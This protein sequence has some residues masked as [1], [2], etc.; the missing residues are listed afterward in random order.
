LGTSAAFFFLMAITSCWTY[1]ITIPSGKSDSN[2]SR[3]SWRLWGEWVNG[4]TGDRR[5]GVTRALR[6]VAG[7]WCGVRPVCWGACQPHPLVSGCPATSRRRRQGGLFGADAGC[8]YDVYVGTYSLIGA[9]AFL[10]G[11]VR[12]TISLTVIL[13]E[14]TNE[15]G[16]PGPRP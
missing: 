5:F 15:V 11:V 6:A 8:R 3:G 16:W 13:V 2:G 1:G 4:R 7:D 10:G 14:A 9:A 12:M